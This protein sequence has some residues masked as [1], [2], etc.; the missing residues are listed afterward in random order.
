MD[1]L[2]PAISSLENL[3]LALGIGLLIGAERERSNAALPSHI[4]GIRTFAISALAGAVAVTLD[5][6][7]IF[8]VVLIQLVLLIGIGYWRSSLLNPGVTTELALAVLLAA[9]KRTHDFA[10]NILSASEWKDLVLFTAL[11]LILYPLT[12]DVD[13]GPW[14]AINP[15]QLVRFVVLIM[16][17]GAL[18]HISSRHWGGHH[19]LA[20]TGFAGGFV[21]STATVY[22][23]GKLSRDMPTQIH[24]AVMGA[25]L[26]S[27]STIIQLFLL[28][29]LILPQLVMVFSWPLLSGV[30]C[31]ILYATAMWSRAGPPLPV[32]EPLISAHLFEWKATL[33][34][35]GLVV[36]VMLLSAGMNQWLGQ[37]GILITSAIAGLADAHAIVASMGSLL[38]SGQI[39]VDQAQWPIVA[40]LLS[41]MVSKSWVAWHSGTAAYYMRV[42]LGQLLVMTGILMVFVLTTA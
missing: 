10:Q 11:I 17:I 28:I 19:G 24:G 39:A 30:L 32:Q 1:A 23:M 26:S 25:V 3:G 9:K 40:A 33:T 38:Q 34:L 29:N 12:P 36:A 31:A 41:N 21:S 8:P 22:A 37:E 42:I 16:A 14:K 27:I 7:G 18:G 4:A 35:V 5:G 15:H 13:M 6:A 2:I 20:L